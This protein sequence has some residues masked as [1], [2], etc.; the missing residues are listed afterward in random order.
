MKARKNAPKLLVNISNKAVERIKPPDGGYII[1]W[2]RQLKGFG[3]RVTAAGVRSFVLNYRIGGKERRAT[4]ARF[5]VL[6][7]D[8]ARE[9]AV[10]WLGGVRKGR[11]PIKEREAYKG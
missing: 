11:D 2:D 5:G 1:A 8:E 10:E 3:I 4:I 7:A 9:I 6:S